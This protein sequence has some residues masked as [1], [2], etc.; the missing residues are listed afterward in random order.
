MDDQFEEVSAP[1][2]QL[3]GRPLFEPLRAWLCGM[4]QNTLPDAQALSALA[5]AAG[6]R[7]V[8]GGGVAIRFEHPGADAL[9]YE[10]RVF[11]SGRVET[12][13]GSWHDLFNA[14]SWLAFPRT[15]AALNARHIHALATGPAVTGPGRGAVRDAATQFDE[16]GV[17]VLSRDAEL[18][19]MLA[20][21]QWK[22]LFWQR[23]AELPQAMRFVV[24]GHGLYDQLRR[25]FFGLCGKAALISTG[26]AVFPAGHAQ[27]NAIVDDH[28]A[29]RFAT[30][31]CYARP[32]DFA[33]LPMLGIPGVVPDS[34][35]PEYYDD[36]RQFRPLRRSAASGA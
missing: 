6:I 23:R 10:R 28:L 3:A 2:A 34:E 20:E 14:L 35:L 7:P 9:G 8:S 15:K 26:A 27:L 29:A 32:R 30:P 4:H 31:G 11:E 21:H 18:L 19:Q 24:I 1:P 22:A 33:P 36:A 17:A 12:R 5:K 13:P 25:P 16:C